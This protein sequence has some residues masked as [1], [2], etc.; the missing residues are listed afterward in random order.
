MLPLNNSSIPSL[1]LKELLT[2]IAEEIGCAKKPSLL[3]GKQ[4]TLTMSSY[5]CS[6][7][8]STTDTSLE[9]T[10]CRCRSYTTAQLTEACQHCRSYIATTHSTLHSHKLEQVPTHTIRKH[11]APLH[12]RMSLQSCWS[13]V[14]LPLDLCDLDSGFFFLVSFVFY[15]PCARCSIITVQAVDFFCFVS[16]THFFPSWFTSSVPM[17]VQVYSQAPY[18][19]ISKFTHKLCTH[20]RP[21]SLTSFA[22]MDCQVCLPNFFLQ[23]HRPA[24]LQDCYLWLP[25]SNRGGTHQAH[26]ALRRSLVSLVAN[27]PLSKDLASLTEND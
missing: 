19:C 22:S 18:P 11:N 20:G 6:E 27:N 4:T 14:P 23:S 3:N 13:A 7:Q 5:I 21:C 24:F 15:W 9:L 26:W 1:T 25:S 2:D 8:K 10:R 16:V 12:H 17:D